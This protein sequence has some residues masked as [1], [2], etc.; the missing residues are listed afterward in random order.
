MNIIGL[1]TFYKKNVMRFLR[2]YNQ[3]LIAPMINA[4]LFFFIFTVAFD[5]SNLH[6][7]VPYSLLLIS[8]L[9]IMATI[10]SAYSDGI[11]IVVNKITGNIIDLITVPMTPNEILIATCAASITRAGLVTVLT[12]TLL[13][14]LQLNFVMFNFFIVL[15]FV[16]ITAL[17]CSLIGTICGLVFDNF[18]ETSV[19][20][21][22]LIT[23]LMFLSGTFYSISKL[24]KFFQYIIKFN[25]F[26]YMIDGFRYGMIGFS[27]T[28]LI[29]GSIF[30]ILI[31]A[32]L[33]FVA[34]WILK[35][36]YKIRR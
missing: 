17:I 27:D 10:N 16:V 36:G 3:T 9:V 32:T 25:P 30:L 21:N 8:G 28:K 2:V 19:V 34:H 24:P 11:I 35:S 7:P 12:Y 14:L 33:W 22:Y 31:A 18:E 6:G 20:T 1:K 5:S 26:F 15:F 29:F 4:V 13:S 23:P